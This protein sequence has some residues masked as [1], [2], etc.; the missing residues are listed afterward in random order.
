M[1]DFLP[2]HPLI[3]D[4]GAHHGGKTEHYLRLGAS[5]VVSVEPQASCLDILRMK[6]G[7]QRKVIIESRCLSDKVGTILFYVSPSTTIST[8]DLDWQEGR[9][10]G[11]V[12]ERPI[13]MPA[14]TLDVLIE[15]Y[16]MPDFC[17]IDVEGYELNVLKG[18]SSPIPLIS[19]EFTAEYLEKKTKPC[20]IYLSSLGYKKFNVAFDNT[21]KFAYN[22]WMDWPA[23]LLE[24]EKNPDPLY[25]GDI[26]ARF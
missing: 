10:K 23:L 14:T 25:W 21:E 8:A 12:W 24:I 18:M 4:V 1:A 17:K 19:F 22:N 26:Y 7:G 11:W 2:N 9:F 20:L 13:E 15:Q 16:G 6:F 5:R 3:F